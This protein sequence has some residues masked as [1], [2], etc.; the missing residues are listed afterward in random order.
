MSTFGNTNLEAGTSQDGGGVVR[1]GKFTL[2]EDATPISMSWGGARHTG[3]VN[4]KMGIY[5][6]VAGAPSVLK[7]VTDA[8]SIS[9][10]SQQFWTASLAGSQFGLVAGD[11]WLVWM[12]DDLGGAG[13][14]FAQSA[15]STGVNLISTTYPTFPDPFGS[16]STQDFNVSI[17]VT[18]TPGLP[19]KS[20]SYF[21]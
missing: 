21:M 6:D 3:T 7:G 15:L 16:P 13:V 1:G 10:S 2:S 9:S 5:T 12:N 8:V 18:Y 20:Y 11:Y 4:L 19:A 17:Y 14:D